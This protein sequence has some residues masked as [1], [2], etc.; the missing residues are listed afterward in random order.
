MIPAPVPTIDWIAQSARVTLHTAE[1]LQGYMSEIIGTFGDAAY[2]LPADR[3]F[4]TMTCMRPP[5]GYFF[6]PNWPEER[7]RFRHAIRVLQR[8]PANEDTAGNYTNWATKYDIPDSGE[9]ES[10]LLKDNFP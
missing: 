1:M 3:I 6:T 4:T 9:P 7:K 2:T 8:M 10:I 5:K